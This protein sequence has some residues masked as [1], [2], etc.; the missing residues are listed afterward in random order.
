MVK[1][2]ERK[3]NRPQQ[4]TL[5]AG[6]GV[7]HLGDLDERRLQPAFKRQCEADHQYGENRRKSD[8]DDRAK[9]LDVLEDKDA[10]DRRG[11]VGGFYVF[12]EAVEQPVG[13]AE[14]SAEKNM[15]AT[16]I[17]RVEIR[18]VRPGAVI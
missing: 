8:V 4:P 9:I 12:A 17:I 5:L 10:I 7:N 14:I 13:Y 1:K 11:L 3:K 2:A 18:T 16:P 6:P 15:S